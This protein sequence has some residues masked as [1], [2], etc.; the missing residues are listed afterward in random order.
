MDEDDLDA[1]NAAIV[2]NAQR[3]NRTRFGNREVQ[4]P[5]L[6]D[7]IAAAQHAA[8]TVAATNGHFGLRFTRLVPPGCG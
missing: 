4:Q 6:K 5:S 1:I 2:E 8:G 3:P 7:Q